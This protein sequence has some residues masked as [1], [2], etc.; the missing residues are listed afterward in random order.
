MSTN[1]GMG[2]TLCLSPPDV[3]FQNVGTAEAFTLHITVSFMFGFIA[4]FPYVFYQFWQFVRPGLYEKEQKAARGVVFVCS[5]LLR[6][7]ASRAYSA[8]LTTL[9]ARRATTKPSR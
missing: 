1:L 3:V 8:E 5:L 6:R 9:S 4:A 7:C 2:E